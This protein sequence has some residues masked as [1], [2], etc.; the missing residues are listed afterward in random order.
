MKGWILAIVLIAAVPAAFALHMTQTYAECKTRMD[1]ISLA[2]TT[3][4]L[5]APGYVPALE[6]ECSNGKCGFCKLAHYRPGVDCRV[7]SDCAAK[8]QCGSPLTAQCIGSKC[9]CAQP[10]P[11]CVTDRDCMRPSFL[12]RNYERKVCVRGKCVIPQAMVTMLP[13]YSTYSRY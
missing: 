5:C 3:Q 10:R 13:R 7:D 6:P 12:T 2:R 11:E 1:C 4:V 9:V 8:K